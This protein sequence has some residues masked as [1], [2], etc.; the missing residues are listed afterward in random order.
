[1]KTTV[2]L[3]YFVNDC[4]WGDLVKF[5]ININFHNLRT[6]NDTDMKLGLL[7]EI[8]KR[9]T[10][11]PKS[12][13]GDVILANHDVAVIFLTYCR[14]GAIGKPEPIRNSYFFINNCF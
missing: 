8:Q 11:K 6:S 12:F 10:K 14:F 2:C 4:R 5:L 9:N 7:S 1:M 3:K 13:D